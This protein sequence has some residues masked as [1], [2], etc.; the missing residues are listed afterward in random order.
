MVKFVV[1]S[2]RR[3]AVTEKNIGKI[4]SDN[5]KRIGLTQEKLAERL[6]V[7]NKTVSKW[8]NG[9]GYPDAGV[10][11]D[12]AR[13]LGIS[14]NTLFGEAN[15]A[16][17][18]K[19]RKIARITAKTME[20]N[21]RMV[22]SSL[23]SVLSPLA[24]GAAVLL[25]SYVG[26][27]IAAF[28]LVFAIICS[29]VLNTVNFSSAKHLISGGCVKDY[30]VM[31]VKNSACTYS[32]IWYIV[33]SFLMLIVCGNPDRLS[34]FEAPGTMVV[35]FGFAAWL[36]YILLSLGLELK[37]RKNLILLILSSVITA[38]GLFFFIAG[39]VRGE[40]VL[41]SLVWLFISQLL[42]Y[43]IAFS[44]GKTIDKKQVK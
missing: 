16:D 36:L 4:I 33:F 30:A 39:K 26:M 24:V 11:P 41:F 9:R 31:A 19:E 13:E 28:V 3:I 44:T 17:E 27:V 7:S 35:H 42:N 23:M 18:K 32:F 6:N 12:I 1:Q 37:S 29:V 34:F 25:Q 5:R 40:S 21:R 2:E 10:I 43:I 8:E 14:I 15:T 38:I 22:V 20:H